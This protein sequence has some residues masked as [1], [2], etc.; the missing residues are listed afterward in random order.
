MRSK[1]RAKIVF[2]L[3]FF[4]FSCNENEKPETTKRIIDCGTLNINGNIYGFH[5]AYNTNGTPFT[6]E[7]N[8]ISGGKT[9]EIR[10]YK[11][12]QRDGDWTGFYESGKLKYKGF[13]KDG[14]LHGPYVSY[15]ENG[16]DIES[17]GE[18]NNG[19]MHGNWTIYISPNVVKEELIYN[20]G[21]KIE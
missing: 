14:E 8:L 10:N 15:F 9:L 1:H 19:M 13:C 20:N 2:V 18:F 11:N 21:E 4:I 6:G 3:I 5:E 17:K 7:C 12:S 16:E